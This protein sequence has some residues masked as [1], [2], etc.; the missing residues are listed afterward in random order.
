M[1]RAATWSS[2]TG[3]MV[4]WGLAYIEVIL[5]FYIAVILGLQG[6]TGTNGN[7]FKH[8]EARDPSSDSAEVDGIVSSVANVTKGDLLSCGR[9]VRSQPVVASVGTVTLPGSGSKGEPCKPRHCEYPIMLALVIRKESIP[10]FVLI[11]VIIG[12]T[13]VNTLSLLLSYQ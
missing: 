4:L 5:R 7:Y 2:L 6:D 3:V 12:T 1:P 11:M 13:S 8:L 9:G 10:I